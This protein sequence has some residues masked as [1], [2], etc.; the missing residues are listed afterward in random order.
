VAF[1]I[2]VGY[3]GSPGAQAALDE[4]IDL[5]G[6]L[7]ANVVVANAYGG[8][9]TYSGAP[10]TP[11][12]KLKEQGDAL[13]R[14]AV[15]RG[16][17][18]TVE[19]EP[20]LVNESAVVGLLKVAVDRRA[21]LIVVGTHGESQLSGMLLGSTAYRLVHMTTRPVVVVPAPRRARKAA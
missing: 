6:R 1:T 17:G 20:V 3:D 15:A 7:S 13:L 12:S 21:G 16:E 5:A 8:P 2:V 14:E 18:S 11:R 9:R 19:L 4:A 10:L